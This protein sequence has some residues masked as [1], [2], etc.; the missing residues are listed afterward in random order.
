MDKVYEPKQ[1]FTCRSTLCNQSFGVGGVSSTC[2]NKASKC[3]HRFL[4]QADRDGLE[5]GYVVR[6]ELLVVEG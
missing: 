1:S 5:Q 6:Q 4:A 3:T 2:A